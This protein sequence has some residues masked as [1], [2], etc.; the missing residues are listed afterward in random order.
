MAL[1][2]GLIVLKTFCMRSFSSGKLMW[3]VAYAETL[4]IDLNFGDTSSIL[5]L[6]DLLLEE[7][8]K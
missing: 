2:H 5:T 7:S 8:I 6:G 4:E 3:C 1:R